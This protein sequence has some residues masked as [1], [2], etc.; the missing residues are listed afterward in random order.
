MKKQQRCFHRLTSYCQAQVVTVYKVKTLGTHEIVY[1]CTVQHNCCVYFLCGSISSSS[2][3]VKCFR[4]VFL[5]YWLSTGNYYH[6]CV[7]CL[8]LLRCFRI[9]KKFG[10]NGECF[11]RNI[12]FLLW[13]RGLNLTHFAN[14]KTSLALYTHCRRLCAYKIKIVII[15]FTY[16]D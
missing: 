5:V 8:L 10:L 7:N 11:S 2:T 15:C 4:R 6:G 14:H 13:L 9:K 16:L 1:C 12:S 3:V